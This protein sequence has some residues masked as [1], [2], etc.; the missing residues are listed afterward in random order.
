MSKP[1]DPKETAQDDHRCECGE[2][3]EPQNDACE[4]CCDHDFDPSEGFT[5]LTCGKDGTEDMVCAAH[6]FAERD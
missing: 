1:A 6:D 3:I 5:C 4:E 2:S